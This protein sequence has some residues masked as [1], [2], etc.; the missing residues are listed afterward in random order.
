MRV[1]KLFVLAA[2][3][4]ATC[5]ASAALAGGPQRA[6]SLALCPGLPTDDG[7][8]R[9]P[10]ALVP[11]DAI[12][13]DHTSLAPP[14]SG[15]ELAIE[16]R[17]RLA[18]V[19]VGGT[20]V[21]SA[22][23][24]FVSPDEGAVAIVYD[25]EKPVC[26]LA[27][28]DF[29]RLQRRRSYR[30][31]RLQLEQ[32]DRLS[33]EVT[34]TIDYAALK[35]GQDAR[36]DQ[37]PFGGAPC[38]ATNLHT[39]GLLVSPYDRGNG[40]L[41]G[42]NIFHT[43]A[44]DTG[45][46]QCADRPDVGAHAMGAQKELR[47]EIAI[48]GKPEDPTRALDPGRHPSGLFF[49]HAHVHGYSALQ[50]AG[51]AS[52]LLT[53]GSFLDSV[54]DSAP[55][56]PFAERFLALRDMQTSDMT[57]GGVT[58]TSFQAHVDPGLCPLRPDGG[59]FWS[60]GTC[61]G[62]DAS[63]K[64]RFTVNGQSYP[65]IAVRSGRPE[66]WR[67]AN[68]SP[69]VSYHLSILP[70]TKDGAVAGDP[71]GYQRLPFRVLSR[72]GT[73]VAGGVDQQRE[74]KEALL[75]PGARLEIELSGLGDGDY[76]LVAEGLQTGGDTWPRVQLAK[77]THDASA[78]PAPWTGYRFSAKGPRIGANAAK[79]FAAVLPK[80]LAN[81][82]ACDPLAGRERVVYLV[83]NPNFGDG[84]GY[85]GK[86]NFGVVAGIRDAGSTDLGN[87]TVFARESMA[88]PFERMRRAM[89]TDPGVLPVTK[90]PYTAAGL[91]NFSPAFSNTPEFGD[92]CVTRSDDP[93]GEVWVIENWTNE[94]H[95]FHI[96][97][98]R[99]NVL[100]KD[101]PA[102]PGANAYFA[103]PCSRSF[104]DDKAP[105]EAG[106]ATASDNEQYA[107]E[108]IY[109]FYRGHTSLGA[110]QT[111]AK[112]S[113]HDSVPVPRGTGVCDGHVWTADETKQA[114]DA[115]CRPGRVA[116]RLVFNRPTQVGDFVYHCHILEHEDRGMM[117]IV[118]VIEP[119]ASTAR[120]ASLFEAPRA[121]LARLWGPRDPLAAPVCRS[122]PPR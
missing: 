31:V 13:Q 36:P 30:P 4:A 26:R 101:V 8:L 54:D 67:L 45:K 5:I 102:P 81:V 46:T 72:D 61:H 95:N 94:I 114:G 15:L 64:W 33:A 58:T 32:K 110:T 20:A 71:S 120:A 77:I 52:G 70:L 113:A 99:F 109:D 74:E 42:D 17:A 116:L 79:R 119:P 78:P 28:A 89:L 86:D 118:H 16:I 93:A 23:T 112:D 37:A 6:K 55:G 29:A 97:Q 25:E 117:G 121:L 108:L 53:I 48:P 68:I 14:V 85:T 92:I 47:H 105:A 66:V 80:P 59:Q 27:P 106:C 9:Q 56:K 122:E 57:A 76:A 63:Q 84:D 107:D 111:V 75:M 104:Y 65:T 44:S 87:V 18:R 12:L 115:A 22:P 51:G 90:Q 43:A 39:H 24:W 88:V 21:E 103:F 69:T 38:Q 62:S 2:F 98:T 50:L 40:K 96:H 10:I 3:A 41:L 11:G 49:F 34:S 60:D 1:R 91:P 19:R 35:A 7:D 100:D 73:A 82:G 83:K